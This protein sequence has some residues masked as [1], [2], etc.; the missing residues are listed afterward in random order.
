[1]DDVIAAFSETDK[2]WYR[3]SVETLDVKGKIRIRYLDFGFNEL[4]PLQNL[5]PLPQNIKELPVHCEKYKMADLK[6]KGRADGFTAQDREKGAKWLRATIGTNVV[7]AACHEVIK[8][9][10]GIMMD[11]EVNGHNLNNLAL[12]KGYAIPSPSLPNNMPMKN[13][14]NNNRGGMGRGGGGG[15]GYPNQQPPQM[16]IPYGNEGGG[17]DQDYLDYNRYQPFGKQA[18]FTNFKP[19]GFI[20]NQGGGGGVGGGSGVGNQ[21]GGGGNQDV[22]KLKGTVSKLETSLSKKNK[23]LDKLKKKSGGSYGKLGESIVQVRDLRGHSNLKERIIDSSRLLKDIFTTLKTLAAKSVEAE[24]ACTVLRQVKEQ[25]ESSN[26]SGALQKSLKNAKKAV[27]RYVG[28]YVKDYGNI[29]PVLDEGCKELT[30]VLESQPKSVIQQKENEAMTAEAKDKMVQEAIEQVEAWAL[31]YQTSCQATDIES[32]E[33]LASLC[34]GKYYYKI[35][36]NAI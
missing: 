17:W 13:G 3:G 16:R 7:K 33:S 12:K 11:A 10:G 4:L 29:K 25:I 9:K 8:Y 34:Q 32:N 23:E 5:R 21:Q 22:K 18:N 20:G 36:S 24:N 28:S 35:I 1:M 6:P 2:I 31:E 19:A 15:G 14:R 30:S 27:D 26:G